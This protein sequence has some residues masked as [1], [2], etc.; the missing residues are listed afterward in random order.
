MRRLALALILLGL[1]G[2]AS[3]AS[4]RARDLYE[5]ED[6]EYRLELRSAL[7]GSWLLSFPYDDVAL[8]PA[9]PIGAALF[10]LRL[11]LATTLGEH[12]TAGVAYE[13]RA[14]SSSAVGAGLALLPPTSRAP[15]RLR[16][17]DW[18]IVDATPSYVHRHELDRAYIALHLPFM[19]LTLGRQAIGLGRGALFS[20]VD[21]F[22]P[23]SPTE[24]DR[25]WRRGVDAAHL[26]LRLPSVSELSGDL[27]A[28]FGDLSASGLRSWAMVGRL[29]ALIGEADAAL[30]AGLRDQDEFAAAVLS[31]NLGEAEV[32]GEFA[33]FDT[34]GAGIDGGWLGTD[35][36]VAK[37]L[38][39]GSYVFDLGRGLRTVLEYHYSG[40]GVAR[41]GRSSAILF[42]TSF[43]SRLLRG[44]SQLL[45]R[46]AIALIL[47]TEL[48]DDLM[49]GLTYIQSPIDGS[50]LLSPTLSWSHSDNVTVLASVLLPWGAASEGGIPR[51]EF[52]ASAPTIF[53]QARLYD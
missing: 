38:I 40:F 28:A 37:A 39:G 15:F 14:Q 11:E 52:G 29:R 46:H 8:G 49:A 48:L 41:I 36:L 32:H 3:P 10:R 34:D 7:K 30:I 19:E 25:E 43:Q 18:F 21:L 9:D 1:G 53:V 45:G 35:A 12:F 24:V 50:G 13:H 44:D 33:L 5:S 51:S 47:G 23:F 31:A 6:G 22:A 17:L 20:A 26:E 2:L 27:I 16:Q 4:L 42:D